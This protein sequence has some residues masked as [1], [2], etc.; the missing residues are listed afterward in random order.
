MK[1]ISALSVDLI[2]NCLPKE[3]TKSIYLGNTHRETEFYAIIFDE[4]ETAF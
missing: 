3:V 2:A 4:S 1:L